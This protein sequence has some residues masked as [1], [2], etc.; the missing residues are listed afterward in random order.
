MTRRKAFTLIELLVVIAIIAVLMGILMPALRKVR[1]Q[2][3]FIKCRANMR[4]WNFVA[5]MYAG[6]SNGLLWM[7][8]PG[9][10]GYWCTRYMDKELRDWKKNKTWFCPT[11]TKPVIDEHGVSHPERFNIWGA[12]GIMDQGNAPPNGISGS[13]GINGYVLKPRASDGTYTASGNYESGVPYD[14]GWHNVDSIKQ[15]NGIPW[16]T[17]ALRFDQWPLPTQKPNAEFDGWGGNGM[18]R[19][20]INR[21]RGFVNI[22]FLDW[23]VRKVGLKELW[24]LKWHRSF[25]TAGIMTQAGGV[26]SSDW[27]EWIRPFTDY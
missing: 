2:A 19:T 3:R 26:Q 17:E 8:L 11:A 18:A 12:W 21:H 13:Y 6:E 27:P 14:Q 20:C 25:D 7:S 5:S 10:P 15:G 9:S 4:Q 16:W 24:T 23:S 22:A 1:D